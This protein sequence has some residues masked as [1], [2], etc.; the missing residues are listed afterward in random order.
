MGIMVMA[1]STLPSISKPWIYDTLFTAS[2]HYL[3]SLV[4]VML[5]SHLISILFPP[6]HL[7]KD[8]ACVDCTNK[9]KKRGSSKNTGS[10][11][12]SRQQA[13]V[14]EVSAA[15]QPKATTSTSSRAARY[16]EE[17]SVWEWKVVV[18]VEGMARVQMLGDTELLCE[19]RHIRGQRWKCI[20]RG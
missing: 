12:R 15:P 8:W 9:N 3:L 1:E 19:I 17:V 6:L 18:L 10:S 16:K 7:R 5:L 11:S 20:G 14:E 13:A 4:F 2:E